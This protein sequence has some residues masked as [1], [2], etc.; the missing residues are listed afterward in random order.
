[1]CNGFIIASLSGQL[2]LCKARNT[3]E[4]GVFKSTCDHTD[5]TSSSAKLKVITPIH[6]CIII[7]NYDL[8]MQLSLDVLTQKLAT[9]LHLVSYRLTSEILKIMLLAVHIHT[10]MTAIQL[11]VYMHMWL[12]IQPYQLLIAI[13]IY[14]SYIYSVLLY[15]LHVRRCD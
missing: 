12:A 3:T 6:M 7:A 9:Y 13:Y 11:A 5:K 8:T 14:I 2:L 1:M 4:F 15:P 10:K